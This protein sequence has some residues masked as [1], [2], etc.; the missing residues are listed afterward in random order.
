MLRLVPVDVADIEEATGE[1][2]GIVEVARELFGAPGDFERRAEIPLVRVG[3]H[4]S[5]G[6]DEVA[7][8]VAYGG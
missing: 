2:P 8:R 7:F 3:S 1:R 4:E 5:A 6:Q